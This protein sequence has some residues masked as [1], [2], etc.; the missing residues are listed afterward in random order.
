MSKILVGDDDKS[1]NKGL[2]YAINKAGY[3][4]ISA[5]DY[6]EAVTSLDENNIMLAI[7]DINLTH[8]SGLDLCKLI[9]NKSMLP[10][11]F[12]TAKDTEEDIVKGFKFGCDDY[13]SKPFS[14]P[15]LLQ[16]IDA[17]LRR[18]GK[19]KKNIYMC[20]EGRLKI[21]F[22]KMEVFKNDDELKVTPKEFKI[23]KLLCDNRGK[24]LQRERIMEKVWDINE[25][26]IDSNS[27]SVAIKRLRE[28][29]EDDSKN[30]KFIIT[31]FGIGYTWG[32]E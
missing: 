21:D 24:V 12:L 6:N 15:I 17:V 25:E 5:F 7:I 2:K 29:I 20:D 4:V 31:V 1:L 3:D 27:L 13:I 8:G 30:P 10:I 9:R 18:S 22:D 23:L 28:K 19:D 26:F 16:R 11:I 14:V 32:I